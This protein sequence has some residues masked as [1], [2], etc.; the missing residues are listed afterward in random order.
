MEYEYMGGEITTTLCTVQP[1]VLSRGVN[2]ETG[3]QEGATEMTKTQYYI[4]KLKE[5]YNIKSDYAV[6]KLLKI[7][8]S[9]MTNYKNGRSMSN[10]VAIKTAELL[11]IKPE[12]IVAELEADRATTKE[13]KALWQSIASRVA[14]LIILALPFHITPGNSHAPNNDYYVKIRR[15]LYSWFWNH[16]RTKTA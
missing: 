13:E 8:T 2:Y 11:N 12:L 9:S 4:L 1:Y 5:K 14:V 16:S 6:A 7:R 15:W 3:P 10:S